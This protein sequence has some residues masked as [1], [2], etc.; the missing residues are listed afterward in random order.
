MYKR[1]KYNKQS[2]DTDLYS[3]VSPQ[4]TEVININRGYN[5]EK[6]FSYAPSLTGL[7]DILGNNI[8][9][10]VIISKYANGNMLL[11]VKTSHEEEYAIREHI[12]KV[13]SLPFSPKIIRY[14][15]AE[16]YIHAL[17]D[18]QFLVYSFYK[19]LFFISHHYMPVENILNS[20]PENTFFSGE[21]HKEIIEK[22]RLSAPVSMY[23]TL[24]GNMLAI[25][26]SVHDDT[27]YMEGYILNHGK[28]GSF[29]PNP[30][31]IPFM[32]NLPDSIC[33]ED[34]IISD[35]NKPAAIKIKLN[36]I[37]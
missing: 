16:I 8:H 20:D 28:H 15:D 23:M 3:Y 18:N 29:T 31:L 25:D 35:E 6:L 11:A 1:L 17:A 7:I 33:V 36:K 13:V 19:G 30:N 5:L 12:E 24:P 10:P 21:E 4:A 14:K 32:I 26:Y 2:F 9:Y 37:Y 34:Y 27:I 22:V